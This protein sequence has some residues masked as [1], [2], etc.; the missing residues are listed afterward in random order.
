MRNKEIVS[1]AYQDIAKFYLEQK[2]Y[3]KAGEY[4]SRSLEMDKGDATL[5]RMKDIHGMLFKVDSSMG[6]YLSAISHLSLLQQ[7]KDSIFNE[8]KS[9]QIEELQ[10]QYETEKKEQN[11]K[12]L[13]KESTLQQGKLTQAKTTRNW[14]L[15]AV[16]LL[17]ILMGL[18]VNYLRLKQKTNEKLEIQQKEINQKNNSLQKLVNEKEWLLKEIHHRVKNNLHTIVGLLDTQSGF[19]KTEEA[20]LALK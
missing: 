1:I 19:L 20:L 15:G 6:N 2:E 4:L 3:A 17:V 8:D 18:L 14:I 12:L 16:V 10:I 9:K 5:S 13:E 11:I 7:I